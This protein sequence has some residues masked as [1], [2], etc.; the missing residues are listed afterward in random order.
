MSNIRVEEV[1]RPILVQIPSITT[2]SFEIIG[3][4]L[5]SLPPQVSVIQLRAMHKIANADELPVNNDYG[6]MLFTTDTRELNIDYILERDLKTARIKNPFNIDMYIRIMKYIDQ[7]LGKF[8]DYNKRE[9]NHD[10]SVEYLALRVNN[11]E[12]QA[13]AN[14]KTDDFM[15]FFITTKYE[16][17][18]FKQ[19]LIDSHV[20][21]N[22]EYVFEAGFKHTSLNLVQ[23][24]ETEVY[25]ENMKDVNRSIIYWEGYHKQDL[26]PIANNDIAWYLRYNS[27]YFPQDFVRLKRFYI[28]EANIIKMLDGGL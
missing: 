25:Y 20:R 11:K 23:L 27:G 9:H 6:I 14:T 21:V 4:H 28:T 18:S 16:N 13:M 10:L 3:R 19:Q 15:M 12:I 1:Q 26:N 5:C 2:K 22:K 7:Y 24:I 8:E 17:D